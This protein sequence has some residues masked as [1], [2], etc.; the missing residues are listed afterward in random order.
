MGI[1][2]KDGALYMSTGID[3]SGLS[4]GKNEAMGII[5]SMTREI[6]SFDVFAG[7][8]TS[9]AMAFAAAA[10]SSYDFAKDF[11]KNMKEVATLSS[12]IAG[13]FPK[14][15]EAL[16]KLTT[17][18]PVSANDSA[19]ALYG[20]VSAG[21]DGAAG[22]KM[23]EVSAKAAIGGVT[24]TA[25]AADGLTSIMNAYRISVDE[26]EEV[27]DQLFSTVK[28]GKTTFGEI[29]ASI[30]QAAPT[31]AAFGVELDQLLSALATITKTG[32]PTSQAM[33][34]IRAAIQGTTKV[35]G[36][37]AFEGRTFQEALQY[38][39]DQAGGSASKLKELLGTDE[40]LAAV[41]KLTGE[42]AKG[43]A[44]DLDAISNSAGAAQDAFKMMAETA[45]N[46]L[47]L[48][49]NNI[50]AALSPLGMEIL[51]SVQ[52]AAEAFNKAFADGSI[53]RT[54]RT[55]VTLLEVGAAAWGTYK[56]ATLAAAQAELYHQGL[57]HGWSL[58]M[59]LQ[60]VKANILSRAKEVLTAKTKALN[61]AMLKN[62]YA[63][64]AASL[65][66]LGLTIYKLAK[67]NDAAK[68]AM[69]NHIKYMKSQGEASAELKS[70]YETLL[71]TSA[72]LSKAEGERLLAFEQLK[73]AYPSIFQQYDTENIK[74]ADKL[75][76]LRQINE[77]EAKRLSLSTAS[78][79]DDLKKQIKVWESEK[80]RLVSNA[81]MFNSTPI[82]NPALEQ[83]DYKIDALKEQLKIAET[84]L[85]QEY[86]VKAQAK[87]DKKPIRIK[88]EFYQSKVDELK[89]ER[90]ALMGQINTK[91]QFD[92]ALIEDK[93][94]LES[95]NAEIV[96]Y[97]QLLNTAKATAGNNSVK[98]KAYWEELKRTA[99]EAREAMAPDQKGTKEWDDL[100]DK[101]KLAEDM[102]KSYSD[103]AESVINTAFSTGSITD[104]ETQIND[105]K[106]KLNNATS[107]EA[108]AEIDAAIK[109][110]EAKLAKMSSDLI[111]ESAK[112]ADAAV[113]ELVKKIEATPIKANVEATVDFGKGGSGYLS[114]D[115]MKDL[116]GE[117]QKV[118]KNI[119]KAQNEGGKTDDILGDVANGLAGASSALWQLSDAFYTFGDAFGDSKML[120]VAGW[121]DSIGNMSSIMGDTVKGIQ[122]GDIMSVINAGMQFISM[123]MYAA[124]AHKKALDELRVS[125]KATREEYALLIMQAELAF[126]EG[127]IFGADAYKDAIN[128]IDVYYA[129]LGK[130][131]SALKYYGTSDRN[132]RPGQEQDPY[133]GLGNIQIVTGHKKTGLFGWGKGKDTYSSV[134]DV[135]PKLIEENGKF[136]ISMA[137]SI[138]KN[139][140]MSDESR[141]ALQAMIDYA[142]MAEEAWKELESYLTGV[143][144]NMGGDMMNAI[145][146]YYKNGEDAAEAFKK[147]AAGVMEQLVKDMIYSAT[148][149]SIFSEASEKITAI[150]SNTNLSDKEKMDQA[151]G[152]IDNVLNQAEGAIDKSTEMLDYAKKKA[153][154][155]GIDIFSP[156]KD[157]DK[158]QTATNGGFQT[159]SQDTGSELNGR[160]TALQIAGE[161]INNQVMAQT[162]LQEAILL[163]II[164]VSAV[165]E[166]MSEIRDINMDMLDKVSSIEKHTQKLHG[167]AESLN[168]ID[169]K[170]DR[171]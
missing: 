35:L 22:L 134:L 39:Y 156:D 116:N 97:E 45:D 100:T 62:P 67:Q 110:I 27:S 95:L 69:E 90:S 70:K 30:S 36:D 161:N 21:Y 147:T 56:V 117:L 87:F 34:Q 64:A 144:G 14:Y 15:Q 26:A 124:A 143:F 60:A 77:E 167:M 102:L 145:V 112:V 104:L 10:K 63:I 103:T 61:A 120:D 160:F 71:Y 54:V 41:L 4:K 24:E 127:G 31:A 101:I 29:S 8:G 96:R 58:S 162:G 78:Y 155:S 149:G 9:A 84:E 81:N 48:L 86:L 139:Q 23:L 150:F 125:V 50:T 88:V 93:L 82:D 43:A 73:K 148:L 115:K 168:N 74:L 3:N 75:D 12:E 151:F 123:P 37:A 121:M 32:T 18:I 65:V 80:G 111:I 52:A 76:I 85:A 113:G 51:K 99:T 142:N 107:T 7:I 157:N 130:L 91:N 1:K 57:S 6:T 105:L 133:A 135:Y 129:A 46:Q 16:L 154:E 165:P 137:E 89:G 49:A 138:L 33:T 28:L 38:L 92:P 118:A 13:S 108:R 11:Q 109:I 141:Q 68:T 19:K 79:I 140:K 128:A 42:N 59:Q 153:E 136:N 94:A 171:L 163:Q 2:D 166:Y 158:T 164:K 126:N 83:I 25:T 122:S 72:D 132:R 146:E 131:D 152:I 55:L 47:K 106:K 53:E 40:A 17:E 169:K 66:A 5:R 98:N 44:S 119:S 159:M 20:I 170:L 114:T